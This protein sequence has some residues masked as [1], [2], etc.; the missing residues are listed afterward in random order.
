MTALIPIRFRP[1]VRLTAIMARASAAFSAIASA[2]LMTATPAHA[3]A[4]INL[5]DADIRAFI[6]D[7]AKTTGT[8]FVIDQRVQ[9]KVSVASDKPLSRAA[10]FELFLAT[11]RANG[12]VAV[13]MGNGQYRVQPAEPGAGTGGDSSPAGR[14]AT[15]VIP[16]DN[17]DAAQAVESLR[18][19]ISRS[20]TASANRSGNA[21]IITDFADNIARV[22]TVLKEIDKDRTASELVA[23][24]NAGAR[25]LAQS[26]QAIVQQ[27]GEQ[28]EA[29]LSISPVDSSN[30]LLIRGDRSQVQRLAVLARELDKKAGTS[31]TESRVVFL[32]HADAAA[33]VPV[34]Q[35]LMGQQPTLSGGNTTAASLAGTPFGGGK[36]SDSSEGGPIGATAAPSSSNIGAA[37]GDTRR[38]AIIARYD[39]ANA[40]IISAPPM[41]QREL[42]EVIRQLDTRRAQV[43]VEAIIVEISDSAAKK[44][45]VQFMLAGQG[46]QVPFI[47]TNFSNAAPN[48]MALSGAIAAERGDISGGAADAFQEAAVSSLLGLSGTTAGYGKIGS[49]TIFGFVVNAVKSDAD[50]NVL[51]TPSVLTL[52]NQPARIL[53]GQEIPVTTGEALGNNLDNSF[54]TVDRQDVGIQLS[55]KPQ[56]N[57][58]GTVTLQLKQIVSSIASTVAD[59]DFVLNKRELETS[60]TVGNGQILAL[61]GLLDDSEH[62]SLQKVPLLGDI[63]GVGE[64]FKS[65]T[66]TRSKTNLMIFI[67]PTI[68]QSQTDADSLTASRWDSARQAQIAR[69]GVS[70]L[71]A[72]AWSYLR[73]TPPSEVLPMPSAPSVV[74]E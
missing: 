42:G 53:V 65:R 55:V 47:S 25:D 17:I 43:Q 14:F 49:D 54:R 41:I 12:F 19:V 60:V 68:I 5:R 6:Q 18:P 23:L 45:G 74:G 36:S 62:K 3:Q 31:S 35:Q 63:P 73:K 34:L 38:R 51:S 56:I 69:D 66:R 13:P 26:L 33:I 40:I 20:G 48:L 7:V 61:G 57:A 67:R 29:K 22:R 72:M 59:R 21:V 27:Q 9:G 71:D 8:S 32:Q 30:A 10:Y 1:S 46:G 64:L 37:S 50:S 24:S 58:G 39:G 4:M 70:S 52:D 11:L 15:A 28:G 44:L 2:T 16:L